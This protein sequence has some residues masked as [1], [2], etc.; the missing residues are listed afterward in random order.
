MKPLSLQGLLLPLASSE[1]RTLKNKA[2]TVFAAKFSVMTLS[3]LG[4]QQAD[5][6]EMELMAS[7]PHRRHV[8][9]VSNFN[10]LKNVQ[11]GFISQV[12]ASVDD[13]LNALVSGEEGEM[14]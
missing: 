5:E 9:N 13:Q 14:W 2:A 12:C 8:Y 6:E 3:I 11:R 7:T 1:W 4:I 10:T